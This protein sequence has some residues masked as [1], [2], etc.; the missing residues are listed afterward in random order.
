MTIRIGIPKETHP[1]EKR[2]AATPQTII[3]LKKL[4][5]DVNV[6]PGAGEGINA[7]DGE[8]HEAGANIIGDVRELYTDSDV[9]FKVRPPEDGEADL[10]REGGWLIG[11]IW[12]GQNREMLDRLA[13]KKATVFAMDSVP[14]ITRAQKMDTLSAMANIAGY[15]R[16]Y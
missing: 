14:R 8:Y 13:K 11:F 10:L 9:I 4:G 16:R 5:F 12:P 3:R 6:E 7:L 2:V 15:P 1:G